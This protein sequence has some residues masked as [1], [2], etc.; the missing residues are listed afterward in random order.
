MPRNIHITNASGRDTT[1][2]MESSKAVPPPKRGIPGRQVSFKRY[3]AVA[4][5]GLHD[6]LA[7]LHGEEYAQALIDGDPDVNMEVVGRA[8]TKTDRVF[9]SG[10][11]SVLYAAP[12]VV[13]L[14]MG[15]DGLERERRT[16]EDVQA[17][18]NDEQPVRW[19]GRKMSKNDVV[20]RFA[21]RRSV[22]LKHVDGLTYDYLFSIAK[23]LQD[24]GM[25]VL[26]GAGERGKAPLIF[27]SNGSP[28]RGFLEGR[29][30]GE[31][32][33]LL[34]HLSNLELKRPVQG[35]S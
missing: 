13:E 7:D 5:D 22:Q 26:M 3:V 1:V 31:K 8:I 24:E 18:V 6:S 32:Y 19:T 15:P 35:D 20:R 9:L 28:Y 4:E 30:E 21:F 14:I 33:K 29:V 27:T 23:E 16:P 10:T 17:N 25:M 12:E 2:A 34:L 11:G